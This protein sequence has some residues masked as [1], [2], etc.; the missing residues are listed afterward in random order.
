MYRFPG[1]NPTE[2]QSGYEDG[3]PLQSHKK[4]NPSIHD[5]SNFYENFNNTYNRY[6]TYKNIKTIKSIVKQSP[7]EITVS[8]SNTHKAILFKNEGELCKQQKKKG[9]QENIERYDGVFKC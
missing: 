1:E 8:R 4:K 3:V 7:K 5:G 2:L 9:G 6:I